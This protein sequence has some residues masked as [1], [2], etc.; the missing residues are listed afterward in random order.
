MV[1]IEKKI[2]S[3]S[4]LN[5][6]LALYPLAYILGNL[7]INLLSA[8]IIIFS[9]FIFKGK[10]IP[11]VNKNLTIVL[12]CFFSYLILITLFS[13]LFA[14]KEPENF[15][16]NFW[17]SILY[18][19]YLFLFFIVALM[20]EKGFLNLKYFFISA[21]SLSFVLGV[22][23][24]VQYNLGVDLFG[25]EQ[26][27]HLKNRR[28]S[29]FFGDE[30]IAGGYLYRFSFFAIFFFCFIKLITRKQ[31]YLFFFITF[32]F[33]LIT[34]FISGN[35][36][37][38]VLF[39]FSIFIFSIIEKKLRYVSIP[40][41]VLLICFSALIVKTE[42][43]ILPGGF[44]NS[45]SSFYNKSSEII[46]RSKDIV[47]NNPIYQH[48]MIYEDAKKTEFQEAT[49]NKI[50]FKSGHLKIFNAAIETWKQNKLFGGGLRS[51][52]INCDFKFNVYCAQHSHNYF[53]EILIN[54]GVIGLILFLS[55]GLLSLK[56]FFNFY[57]SQN[58]ILIQRC[59]L[60]PFFLVIISEF[61][62]FR[63]AGNF[64]ST[65][66]STIFFIYLALVANAN[67][68]NFINKFKL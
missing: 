63:S 54:T 50:E 37:P 16:N 35:R 30:L 62:P 21:A 29:G 17:K 36:M 65:F 60:I 49:K 64:F 26:P 5:I 56:N 15:L 18:L 8:I 13:Y 14:E 3:I 28:H 33:F 61:M 67:S 22:D 25:F 51:F 1:I 47:T 24:I 68:V 57:F 10:I 20:I 4:F 52:R 12:I 31:I 2:Q 44:K 42:F 48:E 9:L 58:L 19:R 41:I 7:A 53:T 23:L 34:I 27:E 45:I 6:L 11:S 55:I 32:I 59:V 46:L 38:L 39:V 40:I 66:N 43:K